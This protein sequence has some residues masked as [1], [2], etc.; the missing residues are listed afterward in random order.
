MKTLEEYMTFPYPM[1]IVADTEEGGFIALYPHLPGCITCG[2]TIAAAKENAADAKRAWLQ[3]ALEDG[4][5][6][7][8]CQNNPG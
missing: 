2:E 5:S 6:I 8:E 4:I 7:P 3:A 1:Q